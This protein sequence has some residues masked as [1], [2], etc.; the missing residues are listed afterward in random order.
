MEYPTWS[1]SWSISLGAT[2]GV[3]HLERQL[4]YLTS[5]NSW[6]IPLGTTV[7]VS[8]LEQQLEYLT[9]DNRW[10]IS[11]GRPNYSAPNVLVPAV[12][13]VMHVI[14]SDADGALADYPQQSRA[15][16]QARPQR[17][18]NLNAGWEE[19][20]LLQNR[21][22]SVPALI[23]LNLNLKRKGKKHTH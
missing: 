19:G 1:N 16:D 2:V 10:T 5:H 18:C 3:P 20:S 13:R 14:H 12:V 17:L 8:R 23:N 7:G 21:S 11:V 4:E 6:N 15:P 22:L 9:R